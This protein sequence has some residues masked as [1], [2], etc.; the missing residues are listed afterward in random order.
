M[1]AGCSTEEGGAGTAGD[2]TPAPVSPEELDEGQVPDACGLLS[3]EEVSKATKLVAQDGQLN[4][5]LVT[6]TQ[7]VCEWQT[8]EKEKKKDGSKDGNKDGNKGKESSDVPEE[9][10]FVQVVVNQAKYKVARQEARQVLGS[11][12]EFKLK[13]ADAAY[14]TGQGTVIGL[15]VGEFFSQVTNLP[16]NE[17]AL[18]DLASRVAFRLGGED[19][20]SDAKEKNKNKGDKKKTKN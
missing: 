20:P 5:D 13:G 4:D 17:P 1:L 19:P 9:V 3:A 6:D 16:L 10:S 2:D 18:K 8:A 15:K 7:S 14:V 12:P 11:A